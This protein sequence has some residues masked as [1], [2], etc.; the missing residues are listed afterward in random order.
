MKRGRVGR[1]RTLMISALVCSALFLISYTIY[2]YQ[3]TGPTKYSG[4]GVDRYL[5]FFILATHVPLAMAIVPFSLLALWQALKGKIEKHRRTVKWLWPTWIYVS[6]T[7]V[8]IYI[9]LYVL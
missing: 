9:M 3:S 8:A 2:H 6:V 5:Y 7:G 1:H 4:Q